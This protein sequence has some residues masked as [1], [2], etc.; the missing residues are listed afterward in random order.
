[1]LCVVSVIVFVQL[2]R[3]LFAIATGF[4]GKNYRKYCDSWYKQ[5]LC[6]DHV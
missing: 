4:R 2:T 5:L 3:D 1:M 6:R